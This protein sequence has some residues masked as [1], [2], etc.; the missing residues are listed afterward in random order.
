MKRSNYALISALYIDRT[1]GLYSDIYFPIIKYVIVKINAECQGIDKF[2]E[3]ET[4]HDKIQELFDIKIPH[5]VIA[6]TVSK[7]ANVKDGSIDLE[8]YEDG[9]VFKIKSAYFDEEESTYEERE[10]SFNLR[11]HE[12]EAEYKDFIKREG[13]CDEDATFMEFISSNTENILGYFENETEEQVEEKYTSMVFFLDYLHKNN[14]ALYKVA[15]QLFWSSVIVAFLQSERPQVYDQARGC[16]A[17][18]YLD[19]SIAMGLLDLSTPEN[20]ASARDVRDIITSSG[21][22][23]KIH[24]A[25]LEEIKTILASVAQNGAYPGT[26]IANACSRRNLEAPDITKIQ[27]NLQKV[28]ESNGIIVFPSPSNDFRREKIISR[29]KGKE[30]LR[31]L[32]ESRNSLNGDATYSYVNTDMFREAHDIF[33]D[34]YVCD[35][36]KKSGKQN[37]FFLTTN[38]DLIGFCK[39]RHPDENAMISTNKVILDL[40]M[41]NAKP[42]HV[43]SSVL[44]ETMARCLD[45]HRSKV[46]SKLHEV[47]RLF[48]KT[49]E[50]VAPEVYQE[51]LKLLYRRA[52]NVVNAVNEVP[53]D[54]PNAF[55]A[56]L[57]EAIKD[58]NVYFNAVNSEVQNR[59]VALEEEVAKQTMKVQTLADESERKSQFIGSLKTKNETLTEEKAQ[60]IENLT[61][62]TSQLEAEKDTSEVERQGKRLAEFKNRIFEKRESLE[63]RRDELMEELKPWED[64]RYGSFALTEFVRFVITTIAMFTPI[65]SYILIDSIIG[66][67]LHTMPGFL[68]VVFGCISTILAFLFLYY[69]E[70]RR[71]ARKDAAYAKWENK[72]ENAEYKRLVKE[73]EALDAEIATCKGILKDP[74]S[75]M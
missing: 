72:A 56:Q 20:E 71:E 3:A 22:V 50:N 35:R 1:R 27:L 21:G 65:L 14:D 25:T 57:Q 46:R 30:A 70:K 64:K 7:L 31:K 17:E 26:S 54:D 23:L 74:T 37:I 41:H 67:D 61:S 42:A 49:K 45:M 19:T 55:M 28:I 48:N 39:K 52:R 15:N 10:R 47:A 9:R 8:A 24:P 62:T 69:S 38:T 36:R 4:V 34:D 12:I 11:L 73:I 33:M 40:W 68:W 6:K 43:S 59:N 32:A 16:E 66:I 29:Y 44:T 13:T 53:T 18:Y 58:D 51:F 75:Y 5:V 60:L 63:N 2:S